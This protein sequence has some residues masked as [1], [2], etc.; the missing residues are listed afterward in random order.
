M[1][2][3]IGKQESKLPKILEARTAEVKDI[4]DHFVKQFPSDYYWEQAE[5]PTKSRLSWIDMRGMRGFAVGQNEFTYTED[6]GKT[7]K[8]PHLS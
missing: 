2:Q 8:L 5:V 3:D 7:W 6:G 1:L 4:K